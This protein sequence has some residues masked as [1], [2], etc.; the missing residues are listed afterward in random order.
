MSIKNT[1]EQ[2]QQM[3]QRLGLLSGVNAVRDLGAIGKLFQDNPVSEMI[4]AA[5]LARSNM[6]LPDTEMLRAAQ[7]A[8]SGLAGYRGLLDSARMASQL[9][10]SNDFMKVSQFAK[11]WGNGALQDYVKKSPFTSMN[12]A[13]QSMQHLSDKSLLASVSSTS[14]S[15][16]KLTEAFSGFQHL[17]DLAATAGLVGQSYQNM[18]RVYGMANLA[19]ELVSFEE[20]PDEIEVNDDD[21]ISIGEVTVGGIEVRNAI[22]QVVGATEQQHLQKLEEQLSELVK[23]SR[24]QLPPM[25]QA[26]LIPLIFGIFFAFFNPVAESL[27]QKYSDDDAPAQKDITDQSPTLESLRLIKRKILAVRAKPSA[28]AHTL[29]QLSTD[30]VVVLIEECDGWALV[31][32]SDPG[33]DSSLQGWVRSKY[34]HE[35]K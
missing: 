3:Q 30:Y 10:A 31:V 12:D 8:T 4:K 26:I 33:S 18:M 20:W 1:F 23:Q 5:Q 2:F 27:V 16:R 14:E 15:W 21:S 32:W 7:A 11:A 19:N 25:L 34:L 22:T 24:Q 6:S 9:A 28:H 17:H 35:L 13:L 29:G